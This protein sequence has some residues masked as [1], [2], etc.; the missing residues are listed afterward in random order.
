M[1]G[2]LE[3]LNP[4]QCRSAAVPREGT[5]YLSLGVEEFGVL[6]LGV[7]GFGV[8]GLGYTPLGIWELQKMEAKVQPEL[9]KPQMGKIGFLGTHADSRSGL[10]TALA[11]GPWCTGPRG[12]KV[13]GGLGGLRFRGF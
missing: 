1:S 9:Q 2:P 11:L 4:W 10:L 6:G 13:L 3:P 8:S 12:A 5:R 7:Q